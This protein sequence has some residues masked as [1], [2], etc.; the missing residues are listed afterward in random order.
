MEKDSKTPDNSNLMETSSKEEQTSKT[1][2][3]KDSMETQDSMQTR[4]KTPEKLSTDSCDQTQSS[5]IPENISNIQKLK[6]YSEKDFNEEKSSPEIC[7]QPP[8]IPESVNEITNIKDTV[9]TE[10]EG[11]L[12]RLSL[13]ENVKIK[14]EVNE[15]SIVTAKSPEKI[16]L[17]APVAT[18]TPPPPVISVVRTSDLKITQ[19]YQNVKQPEPPVLL[20]PN[21][22]S[23]I[24][25]AQVHGSFHS[26]IMPRNIL[27]PQRRT[28]DPPPLH[29]ALR[30]M[31]PRISNVTSLHRP[32][33][34]DNRTPSPPQG[35]MMQMP[36]RLPLPRPSS[37]N[38]FEEN[39]RFRYR[40]GL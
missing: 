7:D 20:P 5:T 25:I 31:G 14:T 33:F 15:T 6:N 13:T 35:R 9:P 17:P 40:E 24:R 11:A 34:W 3:E 22:P 10:M 27:V 29:S 30:N 16:Q 36:M 4:T 1:I 2:E 28:S 12:K 26:N 8:K 18:F 21:K 32:Q 37:N 39:K 38:I 23:E 19:I